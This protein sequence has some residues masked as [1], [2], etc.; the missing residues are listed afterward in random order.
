VRSIRHCLFKNCAC[1]HGSMTPRKLPMTRQISRSAFA[2][3]SFAATLMSPVPIKT[4]CC[5]L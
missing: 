4:S 3:P 2:F 1:A 5:R